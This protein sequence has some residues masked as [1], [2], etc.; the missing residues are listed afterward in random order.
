MTRIPFAFFL[1]A[2]SGTITITM[3]ETIPVLLVTGV[4]TTL[5]IGAFIAFAAVSIL[6][7]NRD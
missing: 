1:Q 5:L 7:G 2:E 4:I 3:N 6:A